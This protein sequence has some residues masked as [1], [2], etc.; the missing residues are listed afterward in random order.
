[1]LIFPNRI[2]SQ[3]HGSSTIGPY[4]LVVLFLTLC[5][6]IAFALTLRT[7]DNRSNTQKSHLSLN[8]P[9]FI[10]PR[11]AI[12]EASILPSIEVTQ[13][14]IGSTA[15]KPQ[16]ET[17]NNSNKD[18]SLPAFPTTVE[19]ALSSQNIE[20]SNYFGTEHLTTKPS[21]QK[22]VS[23]LPDLSLSILHNQ[24]A[25]LRLMVNESGEID[26]VIIE[27]AAFSENV[28]KTLKDVFAAVKFQPGEINGMAVKFQMRI[29]VTL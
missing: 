10:L 8:S 25:I 3:F 6:H 20:P 1:M 27:E 12:T 16:L 2:A 29:E 24:I 7:N 4:R 28:I 11:P 13:R 15:K 18:T 19:L 23:P 22:D 21:I 9:V 14:P 17:D 26:E 5:V